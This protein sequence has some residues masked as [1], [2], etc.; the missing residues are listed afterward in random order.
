MDYCGSFTKPFE[1]YASEYAKRV[2]HPRVHL[3]FL[4]KDG[5]RI[6]DYDSPK[7]LLLLNNDEI[8]VVQPEK[9]VQ[10]RRGYKEDQPLLIGEQR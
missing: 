8:I 2:G 3:R 1:E 7:S 10:C 6:G 5:R 4:T 9:R